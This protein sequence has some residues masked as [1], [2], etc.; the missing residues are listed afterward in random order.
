MQDLRVPL[1]PALDAFG[2]PA[3]VTRPAPDDIPIDTKGFWI[4][5]L[6][7][8]Q[9]YGTDFKRREPRRVFVLSRTAL[10]TLERGTT[11]VAAEIAGGEAKTWRVDGFDRAVDPDHW[12]AILV[13]SQQ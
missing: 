13:L 10:P 12:R 9:P 5:P 7:E 1:D 4:Q 2:L 6:E 8:A 3:I 11:I